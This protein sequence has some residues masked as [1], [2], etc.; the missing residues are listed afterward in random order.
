MTPLIAATVRLSL[1]GPGTEPIA[2]TVVRWPVV[3]VTLAATKQLADQRDTYLPVNLQKLMAEVY[4]K[5]LETMPYWHAGDAKFKEK[6][7]GDLREIS[8]LL[9]A[10]LEVAEKAI[11]DDSGSNRDASSAKSS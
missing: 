2:S 7:I 1:A 5:A 8:V 3:I 10:S 11:R 4:A 6:C 9:D